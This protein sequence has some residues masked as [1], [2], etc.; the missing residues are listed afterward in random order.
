M[1]V[2]VTPDS[3]EK[4]IAS[5][6]DIAI[7]VDG[8]G[9]IHDVVTNDTDLAREVGQGWRGPGLDRGGNTGKPPEG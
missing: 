4:L 7:V 3:A 9:V 5:L 2:D 8:A 6:S 1:A